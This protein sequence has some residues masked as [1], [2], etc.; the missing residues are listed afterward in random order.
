MVTTITSR[1]L[2]RVCRPDTSPSVSSDTRHSCPDSTR[3]TVVT[4]PGTTGYRPLS[5]RHPGPVRGGTRRLG[6][7]TGRH[8]RR[9]LTN[10]VRLFV[11]SMNITFE[12]RRDTTVLL[13][14]CPLVPS[15]VWT[16]HYNNYDRR[17]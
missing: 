9:R 4:V 15:T 7:P 10:L 6:Y 1:D 5:T 14:S 16:L 12:V 3:P 2:G 13:M 8:R 11:V 17:S